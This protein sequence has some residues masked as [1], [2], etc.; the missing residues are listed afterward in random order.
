MKELFINREKELE[1]L[2]KCYDSNNFEFAVIWGRRRIGKTLLINKSIEGRR[3]ITCTGLKTSNENNIANMTKSFLSELIPGISHPKFNS[4]QELFDFLNHNEKFLSSD[5]IIVFDEYPFLA[6]S[7][8]EL[9]SVLQYSIDSYWKNT[10]LKL[11]LCGSSVS[12]MKEQVLS[13]ESPLYGRTTLILEIK[14]FMLWEMKAYKWKYSNEEI[15]IL[16]SVLGG[17]PRYLNMVDDKLTLK[18]NLYNLFFNNGSILAGET[19]T[20]L[21]E[22]F[23]ETARYSDVLSAIASGK[24]SL[25]DI[26]EKVRMQTG[27]VSFYLTNMIRVGLIKKESPYGSVNNKKSIYTITDGLFRFHYQ[28][29]LPNINMINFGKGESVLDMIVLPSLSRYMGLEWE[30]I[31]ISYMFASFNTNRDSFLYNDLQRWWGGST[32]DK[33]QIEIDMMATQ[34]DKALFGE[35]KW[36][37]SKVDV[38]I[39]DYLK[40]KCSQFDYKCKDWYLFSKSGFNKDL[41]ELSKKDLNIHLITLDEVIE[42]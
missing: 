24:S 40:N 41:I 35:C 12:F 19:D 42:L 34:N 39:L 2:N 3:C 32:K 11:V 14:K 1:R 10:K 38:S 29:I 9:S 17:I 25:N 15:A 13:G 18:E 6:G 21:N 20:L 36:T 23:K 5:Y 4:Y 31:C 22:E 37:N 8:D 26:A 27:T 16:Y 7:N 28:F 30:Q 33:K